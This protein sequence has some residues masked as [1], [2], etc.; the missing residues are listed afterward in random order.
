MASSWLALFLITTGLIAWAGVTL[1]R[2]GDEIAKR[3]G[4]SRLVVGVFLVGAATSLPEIATDV[5][6]SVA[7]SPDLA[8]GDLFGSSMAN[9][10]ILALIDLLHRHRVWAAVK[11]GHARVASAGIGLTALAT[12]GILTPPGVAVGWIG[13]D[14]A[15][16]A[17]AYAAMVA[18]MRRSPSGRFDQSVL[19]PAPT[20]WAKPEGGML[21]SAGLRFTIAALVILGAAPWLARSAKEIA[22]ISGVGETF[23]GTALL[24]LTTSLPEFVASI[25]AVHIGAHDLAVGNLFGSNAFNMAALVLADAAYLPGPILAA[26]DPAQAVAGVSAILMMALALATLV[27]GTETRVRRLEPDAVFVLLAYAGGLTAIWTARG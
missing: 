4:I 27:H 1:A 12:L 10:A 5:S 6:A 9:M 8:V 13:L 25:A 22:S 3:A 11:I 20:G 21:R 14:T 24:A 17:A 26:V 23:V 15:V 19:L 16:I 18:W 7:G 2:S